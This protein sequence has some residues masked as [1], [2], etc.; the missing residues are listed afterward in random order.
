MFMKKSGSSTPRK[1]SVMGD[2]VERLLKNPSANNA[3][4]CN[5]LLNGSTDDSHENA[6]YVAS[7]PE[8]WNFLIGNLRNPSCPADLKLWSVRLINETSGAAWECHGNPLLEDWM[9]EVSS[10]IIADHKDNKLPDVL[11]GELIN[12]MLRNFCVTGYDTSARAMLLR[13]R[14]DDAVVPLVRVDHPNLA[15]ITVL[16]AVAL[17]VGD[18]EN[19]PALSIAESS[20]MVNE[21]LNAY[22]ATMQ[23]LPYPPTSRAFFTLWKLT[24]AVGILCQSDVNKQPLVEAGLVELLIAALK[25]NEDKLTVNALKALWHLSFD[26][27]GQAK[28]KADSSFLDFLEKSCESKDNEVRKS[29]R[30]IRWNLGIKDPVTAPVSAR[31]PVTDIVDSSKPKRAKRHVMV[32]Y[33]WNDQEIVVQ[34]ANELKASG[35]EVWIDVDQM[36]GSTLEAM[37]SAVEDSCAVLCAISDSYKNSAACRTE[38]EYAYSLKKLVIPILVERNYKAR[39]W[40]G[41]LLGSKLWYDIADPGL[42]ASS[43]GNLKTEL[44]RVAPDAVRGSSQPLSSVAAT[45]AANP[46]A[47]TEKTAPVPQV[48]YAAPPVAGPVM[49]Q[50][51][52]VKEMSVEDVSAWLIANQMGEYVATFSKQRFDG[53]SL[54]AIQSCTTPMERYSILKEDAGI[55]VG[56]AWRLISC[57][58]EL[59]M[60][61]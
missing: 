20:H 56:A 2:R 42:R 28:M 31:G 60:T 47:A 5:E 18:Q 1:T 11:G 36:H 58:E 33:C 25:R 51:P 61:K 40:L 35:F 44:E 29:V 6:L 22:K 4:M 49:I 10:Q 17:L 3:I 39:G 13:A 15:K 50:N 34:L 46:P 21:L 16:V 52:K 30:G 14:A 48:T 26:T 54:L 27:T 32:S 57:L 59:V 43:I 23:G 55:P 45:P 7:L 24:I 53:R 37:A 41:A 8:W 38:G 12:W 9:A 19:H